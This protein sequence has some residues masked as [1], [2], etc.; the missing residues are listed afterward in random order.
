MPEYTKLQT[1]LMQLRKDYCRDNSAE[2]ARRIGKDATYVHRLFYPIGKKGAKGI[3]LEI[4]QACSAAFDLQPGF[5]EISASSGTD[6]QLDHLVDLTPK[7]SKKPLHDEWTAAA[8]AIMNGLD[9][10]QKAQMVAKMRE[11]KQFLGPP[12]DGQTLQVAG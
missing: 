5:W 1:L 8:I 6:L 11:Y 9:T 10:T 3:G 7:L 2:L 4:M 12:S